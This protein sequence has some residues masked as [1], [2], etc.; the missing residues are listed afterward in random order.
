MFKVKNISKDPRK[1]KVK[2]KN[3]I[4]LPG[5]EVKMAFP[6]ADNNVFE[7]KEIKGDNK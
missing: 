1:L 5:E 2:G 4:I 3:V 6:P 7:V